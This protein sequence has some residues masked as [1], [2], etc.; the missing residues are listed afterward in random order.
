MPAK[1]G[2]YIDR[3]EQ[4]LQPQVLL[5]VVSPADIKYIEV[6]KS[7]NINIIMLL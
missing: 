6:L 5:S 3:Q 7:N 1:L 2:C 4:L